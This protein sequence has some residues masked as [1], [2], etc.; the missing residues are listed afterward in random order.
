[1]VFATALMKELTKDLL[2]DLKLCY[3][4]NIFLCVVK[5]Y[6]LHVLI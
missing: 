2:S 1:M 3:S 5:I 6:N 4:Q